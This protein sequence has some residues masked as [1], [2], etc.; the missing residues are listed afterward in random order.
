MIYPGFCTERGGLPGWLFPGFVPE[1]GLHG[2]FIPWFCTG[3]GPS[4]VVFLTVLCPEEGLPGVVYA[5]LC[6]EESLPGVDPRLPA[7]HPPTPGT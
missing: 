6:P 7:Y 1:E 2:W 3:R 5:V 4:W